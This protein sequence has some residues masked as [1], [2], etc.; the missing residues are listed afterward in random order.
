[1]GNWLALLGLAV[2]LNLYLSA[3]TLAHVR[4]IRMA[5][6]CITCYRAEIQRQTESIRDIRQH[7]DERINE[8]VREL[9]LLKR[10]WDEDE[11]W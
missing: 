9:E 6:N 3:L 11:S 4:A 2:A 5:D 8:L 10:Q 7:K 1:M